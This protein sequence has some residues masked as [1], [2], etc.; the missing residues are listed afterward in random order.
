[1]NITPKNSR[2]RKFQEG[3]TMPAGAPA[4]DPTMAA[5]EEQGAPE[6]GAEQDPIAQLAQI[7]AQGL[8]NQDCQ[9]LAQGAQAFLQIVS[10]M[11]GGAPE[12]AGEPVFRAGGK[13]VRRIKN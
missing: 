2:T 6:Q 1:M 13:L 5:P 3:G 4:E 10:Q 8:Q 12:P 11:Q 9:L 7:F